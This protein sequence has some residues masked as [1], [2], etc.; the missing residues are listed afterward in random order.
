MTFVLETAIAII[1]V[2]LMPV[3]DRD[4]GFAHIAKIVALESL[5]KISS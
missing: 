5:I 2:G 1:I 4:E 3:K